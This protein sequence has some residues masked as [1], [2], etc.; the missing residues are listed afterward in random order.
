MERL[1]KLCL[2]KIM[3][4]AFSILLLL[5]LS[6]LS[7]ATQNDDNKGKLIIEKRFQNVVN[8]G[9]MIKPSNSKAPKP[10]FAFKVEG[11]NGYLTEFE[12]E[13]T[14]SKTLD[15]LEYGQYTVTE[16]ETHGFVCSIYEDPSNGTNGDGIVDL[17]ANNKEQKII[18]TNAPKESDIYTTI[19][20][21]KTWVSSPI[22]SEI[23]LD[24]YRDGEKLE[25]VKK[26]VVTGPVTNGDNNV[27]TYKW[28]TTDQQRFLKYDEFGRK[29]EYMAKEPNV[30]DGLLKYSEDGH[31]L[32]FEVTQEGN[33]ITNTFKDFTFDATKTWVNGFESDYKAAKIS[34][35]RTVFGADKELVNKEPVVTGNG[36][37]NYKWSN[38][39]LLDKDGNLYKYSAEEDGVVNGEVVINANVYTVTQEGN[40]ITN[41]FKKSLDGRGKLLIGK[42]FE[43]MILRGPAPKDSSSSKAEAPEFSFKVTGP[44]GY[45]QEF[46]LKADEQ[47]EL[48][49]LLFGQYKVEETDSLGFV[50]WLGD[51][52]GDPNDGIVVLS[53]DNDENGVT[54]FNAP[55]KDDYYTDVVA[56]KKWVGGIHGNIEL[57]LY[58]N[59]EKI[60]NIGD[61]DVINEGR[62]YTY[63]WKK[64]LKYD[65]QG[66]E[67]KYTVKEPGI[68]DGVVT[69]PL[70]PGQF[71]GLE[72]ISY[73]VT[74][75]GNN[76]TNT[77]IIPKGV[78]IEATKTWIDGPKVDHTAVKINLYRE[79]KSTPKELVDIDPVITG[80]GP[81]K[82][83]WE[84]L[85]KVNNL[86][87][88]YTYSVKEANSNGYDVLVN[89]RMYRVVQKGNHITNRFIVIKDVMVEAT[90]K[91]VGGPKEDHIRVKLNLYREAKSTPKELVDLEPEVMGE[92]SYT[93]LWGDLERTNSLGEA[94][95]Y[96]VEEDGV[97][98]GEMVVN[99]NTYVVTQQR[100]EI[101]N[102]YVDQE[103]PTDELEDEPELP[104]TGTSN[105]YIFIIL[106]VILVLA[107]VFVFIKKK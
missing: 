40:N 31:T 101:T 11:P 2:K 61:P 4:S 104:A 36:P 90:K 84:D 74:Q 77:F 12:L 15:G 95:I 86:G 17:N 22:H 35:Y 99:G 49:D 79:A 23:K 58:R 28:G 87:E 64:L 107:G 76:I 50:S 27:Y 102:T 89:G 16:T 75:E 46:K 85:E 25:N 81:Y 106:G 93:Y 103:I 37:F 65:K 20:A 3:I 47:K 7:Y 33:N 14:E 13:A 6:P 60:E 105:T 92:G 39:D 98:D 72:S 9:P 59:G 53:P 51:G 44:Y 29:Y 54:V 38:L 18:F 96:T 56:T 32:I 24:L 45:V 57:E 100:N 55:Q 88:E 68:V 97:V 66:R 21:T 30:V 70:E 8:R 34:L 43:N 73:R 5:V 19:V 48:N 82:Y 91:W 63:T 26:P 41:T 52:Y 62:L 1:R 94:Y 10:K 71:G 83:K 67:Y 80:D 69:F 78:T 42:S